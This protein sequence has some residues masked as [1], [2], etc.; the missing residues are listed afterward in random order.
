MQNKSRITKRDPYGHADNDEDDEDGNARDGPDVPRAPALGLG[1]GLLRHA[2]SSVAELAEPVR[3]PLLDVVVLVGPP[4]G[5]LLLP[6]GNVQPS[7]GAASYYTVSPTSH[8]SRVVHQYEVNG[9]GY[10]FSY[11]DV[12]PDGENASGTVA[13][14]NPTLLKVTVGGWS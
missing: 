13:G 14:D 3:A 1:A 7:L 12:N 8:Y 10:A 11:D 4:A 9:I 6:G 2:Y 5:P